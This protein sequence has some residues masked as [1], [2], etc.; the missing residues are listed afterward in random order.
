[1][2]ISRNEQWGQRLATLAFVWPKRESKNSE[3]LW[4]QP[5]RQPFVCQQLDEKLYQTTCFCC[6]K[7]SAPNQTN[8]QPASY[9]RTA[10]LLAVGIRSRWNVGCAKK[11]FWNQTYDYNKVMSL[12]RVCAAVLAAFDCCGSCMHA[13]QKRRQATVEKWC[14]V[15]EFIHLV[16]HTLRANSYAARDMYVFCV[17][18]LFAVER[19]PRTFS[20]LFRWSDD[21]VAVQVDLDTIHSC[22]KQEA[23]FAYAV[24]TTRTLFHNF[25]EI[26]AVCAFHSCAID[27]HRHE[28]GLQDWRDKRVEFL[29]SELKTQSKW[30]ECLFHFEHAHRPH[31]GPYD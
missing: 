9:Y 21:G 30:L 23:N 7:N 1:M 24:H 3:F 10:L 19:R 29:F 26:A 2:Q 20:N 12:F 16:G 14:N 22:L 28:Y 15:N 25:M 18:N 17:R 6:V 8:L 31:T 27:M 5:E 11:G 13:T 4:Q